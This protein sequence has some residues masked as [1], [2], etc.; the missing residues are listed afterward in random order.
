MIAVTVG[1]EPN[2]VTRLVH[3]ELLT[4]HSAYFNA[5]LNRV[6]SWKEGEENKVLLEEDDPEAFNVV[7]S[8]LYKESTAL[9]F[10]DSTDSLT[11]SMVGPYKL[12]DKLMIPE[13]K[14]ALIDRLRQKLKVRDRLM[15]PDQLK[16]I[17]QA[18]LLHSSLYE[19]SIRQFAWTYCKLPK[20]L[21]QQKEQDDALDADLELA[22]ECLSMTQKFLVDGWEDPR[23]EKGC[24]YHDHSD[25]SEC[26]K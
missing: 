8:W 22:R 14:N 26:P 7:V 13:L 10:L 2:Q 5:C 24:V 18:D 19:F 9:A 15:G 4:A 20:I 23:M 16:K 1:K 21:Y 25:G 6:S 3:K 17:R 12:A 11:Y